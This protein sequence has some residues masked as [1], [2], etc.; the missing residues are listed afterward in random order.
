MAVAYIT[1][2]VT[3]QVAFRTVRQTIVGGTDLGDTFSTGAQSY[4]TIEAVAG[5]IP[6]TGAQK[7]T[8]YARRITTNQSLTAGTDII[9]NTSTGNIPYNTTTGV[10]TLTAGLEYS[11]YAD[12]SIATVT[13][14]FLQY[15]L[16]DAT[17][18]AQISP[19]IEIISTTNTSNNSS[20]NFIYSYTPTFNQ[21]V[22]LRCILNG[23][24]L[25]SDIL[26]SLRVV[27]EGT[28]N[29]SQFVGVLSNLY[30]IGNT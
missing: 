14:T 9:L 17:T 29:V 8:L 3:T 5:T 20:S 28:T 13:N 4:A 25:R 6:A 18:N 30:N 19:N 7:Q 27:S 10:I 23:G 12:L 2:T 11:F 22:K 16:V 21:T 15:A 1:P 24:S 26:S